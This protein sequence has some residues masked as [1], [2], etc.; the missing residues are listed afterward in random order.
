MIKRRFSVFV[1]WQMQRVCV[2]ALARLLTSAR[3]VSPK[4]LV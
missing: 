3:V 4:L 1:G 2:Y